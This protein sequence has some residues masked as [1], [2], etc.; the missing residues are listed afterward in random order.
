MHT[1]ILILP[2]SNNGYVAG[3]SRGV[4]A[5]G[6]TP[7]QALAKLLEEADRRQAE[8]LKAMTI[9]EPEGDHPLLKWAGTWDPND[10]V[11]QEWRK[12]VEEYRQEIDNDPTR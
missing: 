11:I 6:A 2:G 5:E 4:T 3:D 10:P 1:P 12:A 8:R 9:A 7:Q